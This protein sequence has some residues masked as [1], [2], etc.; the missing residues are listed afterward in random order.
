MSH[1]IDKIIFI[2]LEKRKD[3]LY[4]ITNELDNYNLKGERFNAIEHSN[5]A[6]GC[7]YSHLSIL[8]IA[9]YNNY[10]NILILEDDFMFNVSKEHFENEINRFFTNI[11]DYDVCMLSCAV[12]E[13]ENIEKYEFVD[14]ILFGKTASGYIV[15]NHYYD[16]L[17]ELYE[18]NI[19]LLEQT[20]KH[21]IYANDVIWKQL[22]EK[23]KWFFINKRLGKQRPGF[24]DLGQTYVDYGC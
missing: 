22:Q 5:G 18:Y 9:K 20:G 19:P 16:K 21:W 14:R 1:N 4:E 15:N 8:K 2:N 11:P 23:D 7:A 10:K 3:R 24:S 17:I 6:V 13:R 12:I